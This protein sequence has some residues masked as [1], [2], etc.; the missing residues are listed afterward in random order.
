MEK[1]KLYVSPDGSDKNCGSSSAP[2]KTLR[3]IR[4]KLEEILA[5]GKKPVDVLFKGGEYDVSDDI[6]VLDEKISGSPDA[7][8]RFLACGK[9]K[10]VLNGGIKL[11]TKASKKVAD[12]AVLSRIIDP[13]ARKKLRAI[14]ISDCIDK[15]QSYETFQKPYATVY[16]LSGSSLFTKNGSHMYPARWPK[17]VNPLDWSTDEGYLFAQYI[18]H[19]EPFMSAPFHIR[20]DTGAVDHINRFWSESS[21]KSS[22][23]SGYFWHN[24]NYKTYPI[25][26]IDIE[27]KTATS[28][29]GTGLH[30]RFEK[31]DEYKYRRF[32]FFNIFEELSDSMEFFIDYENKLFYYVSDDNKDD[33]RFSLNPTTFELNN[34]TNVTFKGLTVT[35][36]ATSM[37]TLEGGNDI[38]ITDCVLSHSSKNG[39]SSNR[40][41]GLSVLNSTLFDFGRNAIVNNGSGDPRTL[42][43]G[44]LLVEG[45]DIYNNGTFERVYN[46]AVNIDSTVGAVIRRNKLHNTPHMLIYLH[47]IDTVIEYNEIYDAVRDTD[48]GS[49]IYW[50]RAADII[51]TTIRYNYFH[52]I[53]QKRT[54]TW[55]LGSVYADDM[56]TSA[57]IYGNLF[58]HACEFG[59]EVN[60]NTVSHNCN[61]IKLNNASFSDIHDN[62]FLIGTTHERPCEDARHRETI[63]FLKQT[64][65]AYLPGNTDYPQWRNQLQNIGFFDNETS[66]PSALWSEHLKGTAWEKM[67]ELLS[68]EYFAH[69][70]VDE[71]GNK[72]GIPEIRQK[73]INENID[74]D[75]ANKLFHEYVT[76]VYAKYGEN[77]TPNNFSRNIVIGMDPKHL[78]EDG[79]IFVWTAHKNNAYI[80]VEEAEKVFNDI[81]NSDFSMTEY[82]KEKING[83]IDDI[84]CVTTSPVE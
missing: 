82:G 57:A 1:I 49:A 84:D 33:I 69:G 8:L 25:S 58:V 13:E 38:T 61:T 76:N 60:S 23:V 70:A 27:A 21:R 74:R 15:I 9:E 16:T 3:G 54:S 6:L 78:T 83:I 12:K 55:G 56:A 68:Y 41:T 37:F 44:R 20:L 4:A 45:N 80:S 10:P 64:L 48:D 77:Y 11:N 43:S 66:G 81:Y 24:W 2:L 62:I 17:K 63:E 50:G 7:E 28:S 65:G 42:T 40:T 52:D 79:D 36:N 46:C 29:A 39:I 30:Y 59:D 32:F 73:I 75:G 71:N 22:W 26:D 53:G 31:E 67:V 5:D 51:G 14:D 47:S 34:A 72:Y 35:L 19:E 18:E